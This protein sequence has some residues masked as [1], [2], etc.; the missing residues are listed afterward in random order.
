MVV[1]P[2]LD[3][4]RKNFEAIFLEHLKSG[5]AQGE[6]NLD[7]DLR[8]IAA[9]IYALNRGYEL[10]KGSKMADKSRFLSE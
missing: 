6:I 10:K 5:V 4:N 3:R 7:K 2:V 9:L 8:S 1:Y